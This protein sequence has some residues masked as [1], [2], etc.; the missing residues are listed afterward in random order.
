MRGAASGVPAAHSV[1]DL[2]LPAF[3]DRIAHQSGDELLRYQL[4]NGR[5]ARLH[6]AS[7]LRGEP[8]LLV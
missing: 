3:P 6:E 8:W 5:G 7:A 1:G 2:L 4:S